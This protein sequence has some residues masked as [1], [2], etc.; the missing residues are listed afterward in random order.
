MKQIKERDFIAGSAIWSQFDFCNPYNED[1]IQGMNQ[2]GLMHYDRTPKD[3]FYMVKASYSDQPVVYIA[4]REWNKR[5][6]TDSTMDQ[7]LKVY[8]NLEKISLI[9]NGNDLGSKTPDQSCTAVWNVKFKPGKNVIEAE[10]L[11][12]G[13][14]ISDNLEIDFHYVPQNLSD[15]FDEI[16]INVGSRAQFIDAQGIVWMEDKSYTAGGWGYIAGQPRS[17][18]DRARK[19]SP[20]LNT[21]DDPLYQRFLTGIDSYRFDVPDGQYELELRFADYE[22]DQPE[23]NVFDVTINGSKM[24]E[25]LDL[26]QQVGS[27]TAFNKIFKITGENQNGI[28][29]DF[30]SDKGLTVLSAVRI[31]KL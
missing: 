28:M 19:S 22:N 24:I 13:Q 5:A 7:P 26:V 8:S 15:G 6:G 4:S 30:K 2:K 9:V 16:S 1:T 11:F 17:L 12:Q 14:K 21:D 31:K 3:V 10:G 27:K 23:V 29:I 20:I 25:N 18:P